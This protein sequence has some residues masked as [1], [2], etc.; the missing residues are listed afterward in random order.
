MKSTRRRQTGL[1]RA[2][3][4]LTCF[5]AFTFVLQLVPSAGLKAMAEEVGD[6]A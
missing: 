2:R 1:R 5:V 6:T 3:N 4:E